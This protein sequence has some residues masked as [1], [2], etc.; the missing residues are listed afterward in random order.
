[1]QQEEAM[2]EDYNTDDFDNV[3]WAEFYENYNALDLDNEDE[4]EF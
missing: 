1:M 2:L 3:D 4:Y